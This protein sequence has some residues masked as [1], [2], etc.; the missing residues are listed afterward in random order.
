MSA[1]RHGGQAALLVAAVA[2][3]AGPAATGPGPALGPERPGPAQGG[4]DQATP[5]GADR[6]PPPRAAPSERLRLAPARPSGT[7][8]H[9]GATSR[10]PAEMALVADRVCV[11]RW[12]AS[13]VQIGRTGAEQP[14]SPY[15]AP[16][17][18]AVLRAAS[19][20]GVIPQGYISGRQ[21][22]RACRLAGKRLCARAEWE[23]A[24]RGPAHTTFPYGSSRRA[25]ACNDDGRA[26]H[27]VVEASRRA[28][29]PPERMWYEGMDHPLINQLDDTL[30]RTGAHPRCT[31][32][33]GT[34][35]MVGNLH[36][37]IDDP[38][39]TFRGGY[40]MDTTRNG[41]GCDYATVAHGFG[42]HDYS[43]GFR[44]CLDADAV[45]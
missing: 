5:S 8:A 44:C 38:E 24:C 12:E 23:L 36:E 41:D 42:Y 1:A 21:A 2:G 13:L 7:A 34:F 17:L 40:F 31:N 20:S 29:F 27:P 32:A 11:D 45:E 14:W 4:V 9:Q 33:Y 25:K 3:C 28:G 19:R 18:P 6:E 39:G 43:T 22:E 26:V 30:Q 37:W 16:E 15:Q 10:C 35:D